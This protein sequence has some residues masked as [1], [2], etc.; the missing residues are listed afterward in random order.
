[1]ADVACKTI[2]ARGMIKFSKSGVRKRCTKR[3]LT[4]M[5][6]RTTRARAGAKPDNK[7]TPQTISVLLRRGKKY[8]A[9]MMPFIKVMSFSGMSGG[10]G[11][12]LRSP[13]APKIVN[14]SPSRYLAII[15]NFCFIC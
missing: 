13:A 5:G 15:G 12:R 9:A 11:I 7:R 1:M 14:N 6:A 10:G 3:I 4:E 2:I 8:W